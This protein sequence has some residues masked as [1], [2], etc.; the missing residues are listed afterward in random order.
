MKGNKLTI[1]NVKEA[2][3]MV[4][5]CGARRMGPIVRLDDAL[6]KD[7]WE[8]ANMKSLVQEP[9]NLMEGYLDEEAKK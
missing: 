7:F 1:Q 9:I 2:L 4:D 3:D 5:K 6:L 8:W